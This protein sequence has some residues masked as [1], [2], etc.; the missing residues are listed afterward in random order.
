MRKRE[1]M[2]EKKKATKLNQPNS[3]RTCA[4]WTIR[5]YVTCPSEEKGFEDHF[6]KNWA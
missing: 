4:K 5:K 6:G 3:R 2:I 1:K